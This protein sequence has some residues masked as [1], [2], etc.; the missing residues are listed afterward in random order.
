MLAHEMGHRFYHHILKG[1]LLSVVFAAAAFAAVR[2]SLAVGVRWLE[3]DSTHDIAGLPL[4]CL[5]LFLMGLF[6][7][8]LR[9]TLS[10]R[11]ERRCDLYAIGLTSAPAF[12]SLVRKLGRKN[13][14]DIR[15]S[16]LSKILFHDHPP[17]A[18]RIRMAES[19]LAPK[20]EGSD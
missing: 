11:M 17:V 2:W 6:F 9:N 3:F 8:P 19:Q 13:L 4:V 18:E 5:V 10:R 14:A 12:I 20:V 15:P 1:G 7:V 16:R